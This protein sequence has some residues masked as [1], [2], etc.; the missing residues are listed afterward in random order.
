MDLQPIYE[1]LQPLIGQRPWEVWLGWGSFITLEFG[2]KIEAAGSPHIHGEWSLWVQMSAWRLE[3]KTDI[4]TASEDSR[5][6]MIESIKRLEGTTLV[7]IKL[8]PPS[9]E[10]TFTF[11]GEVVLH[12]FPLPS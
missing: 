8:Q 3:T 10:T 9:L 12:L 4:I 2:N 6:G 7:S 5:P 1:K 11:E